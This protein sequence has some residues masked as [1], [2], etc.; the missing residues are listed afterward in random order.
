MNPSIPAKQFVEVIPSV[1]QAGA[2]NLSMAGLMLTPD[3]SVPIGTIMEFGDAASVSAWFGPSSNEAALAA[4]YFAGYNGATE[5]PASLFFAQYNTAAV[6]AYIRGGALTGVTLTA[7]HLLNGTVTINVDGRVVTSA[8][9]DLSSATSFSN[10]AAL[11]QAGLQTAGSIFNGTG[12]VTNTSAVLTINTTVSGALHVGD[13]VVGVDIPLGTTILSFGTYTV[14]SGVGTVNLS[15]AA[16]G[17]AGPEAVTVT[18]AATCG[19]DAQRNAFEIESATT[20][21]TS[22]IAFPTTDA[23]TTGLLLTAATGAV[24]SQGAAIAVPAALMTH[25]T[26]LSSNWASFMTTLDPDAGAAGGPIKV[27]F[28]TWASQQAGAYMYVAYDS[29]PLPATQLND[30]ACFGALVA[31]LTGTCPIWSAS[32]GAALAA[33]ICGLTASINFTQP[34]GR[35][36]YAFRSSPSLTPDVNDLT[37][38]L[39]LKANGYNAYCGVATRTA[40]FQWFQPGQISGTWKWIDPYV[41]QIYWNARFQNDFAELLTQVPAIPYTPTGFNT[42]RQAL[43]PDIVAMGEFG[44]WVA[45]VQLSGSQQVAV[46]TAAGLNI[47]QTLSNQGWYLQVKDPGPTVRAARG[48]PDVTFWYTDG[49]A[50][51]QINMASVDVE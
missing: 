19:Y 2:A 24:L 34:G 10:A 23:L 32:Q 26:G 28:A 39:N 25:L 50:I 40:A 35:T 38:F 36:T 29:D 30:A 14:L 37:T 45:G 6:G 1:L 51:Q 4:D 43:M 47:A 5:L 46:N 22:T 31:A 17:S 49:G 20:G 13:V 41:D 11:V 33:F 9:I 12:T 27:A 3:E 15:A 8:A 18:S 7:L 21:A 16:T 48:S 44:A 42:I